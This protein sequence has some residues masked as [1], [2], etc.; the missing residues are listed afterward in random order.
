V[1]SITERGIA[2]GLALAEKGL[3]SLL[4][5]EGLWSHPASFVGTIAKRLTGGLATGAE[6]IGL[7]FLEIYWNGFVGGN[8][9]CTHGMIP[10]LVE[11]ELR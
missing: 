7:T 3:A 11:I 2:S 1:R 9:G 10:F 8:D 4:S 5:G 6:V